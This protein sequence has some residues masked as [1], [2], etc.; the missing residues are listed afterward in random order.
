ML[1]AASFTRRQPA[2]FL[3]MVAVAVG[4]LLVLGSFKADAPA[5]R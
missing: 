1:F 4:L 2:L 5:T 3:A